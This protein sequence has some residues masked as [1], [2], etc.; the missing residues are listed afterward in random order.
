[1]VR[2]DLEK[3]QLH[4]I[5]NDKKPLMRLEAIKESLFEVMK[6]IG[7]HDDN[8]NVDV[9]SE[10]VGLIQEMEIGVFAGSEVEDILKANKAKYPC[11]LLD[12]A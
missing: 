4:I 9:L 5:I 3:G 10:A 1:M 8:L 2:L 11:E 6:Q 12:V 7:R